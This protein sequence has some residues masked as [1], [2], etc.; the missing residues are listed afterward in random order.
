MEDKKEKLTE[1]LS[2]QYSLN[3]ISLE[4]YE[5]L[6]EYAHKIET[7]KEL[8]IFEKIVNENRITTSNKDTAKKEKNDMRPAKNEYTIL[9]TRKTSGSVLN[10]MNGKIIS[11]LGDCHIIINDDDLIED[12]TVIHVIAILGDIVIHIPNNLTVINKAVPIVGEISGDDENKN[13]GQ[14]KRLIIEGQVILGN[15]TIKHRKQ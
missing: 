6:V 12:E 5:R 2:E 4:E 11:I 9:S 3:K 1:E 10:E 8:I 7:E 15:L 14:G 13:S